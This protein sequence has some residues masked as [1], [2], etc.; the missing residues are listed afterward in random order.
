MYD[1]CGLQMA[2]S[3]NCCPWLS[4]GCCSN[5]VVCQDKGAIGWL[6][7]TGHLGGAQVIL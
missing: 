2:S 5:W 3:E 7:C 6:S 4:L 1:S